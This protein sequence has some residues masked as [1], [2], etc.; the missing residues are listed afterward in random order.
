MEVKGKVWESPESLVNT[1]G[2]VAFRMNHLHEALAD[3]AFYEEMLENE[4]VFL[5]YNFPYGYE[6]SAEE[7]TATFEEVLNCWRAADE[8]AVVIMEEIAEAMSAL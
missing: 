1:F 2:F 5:F 8:D 6:P 4:E 7:F 3:A